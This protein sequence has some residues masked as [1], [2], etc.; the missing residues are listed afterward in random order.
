MNNQRLGEETGPNPS[1]VT[2]L[3]RNGPVVASL[4]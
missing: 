4:L 2:A 1:R 3:T